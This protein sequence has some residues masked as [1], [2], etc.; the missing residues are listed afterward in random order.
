MF[1][2]KL[3]N[4][5]YLFLISEILVNIDRSQMDVSFWAAPAN[6]NDTET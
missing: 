6:K 1:Y 4:A 3:L 2:Y 5:W